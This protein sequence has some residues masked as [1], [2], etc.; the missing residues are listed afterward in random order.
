MAVQVFL[1][2]GNDACRDVLGLNRPFRLDGFL[3]QPSLSGIPRGCSLPSGRGSL[4]RRL[5][6]WPTGLVFAL[7]WAPFAMSFHVHT[8]PLVAASQV[9]ACGGASSSCLPCHNSSHPLRCL[10]SFGLPFSGASTMYLASPF[11]QGTNASDL[12]AVALS[13]SPAGSTPAVPSPR[14]GATP[15]LVHACQHPSVPSCPHL[16]L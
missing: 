5:L 7:I 4:V 11:A 2:A 12:A 10:P 14:A 3:L 6:R 1:A 13:A 9:F 8:C 16:R 15:P